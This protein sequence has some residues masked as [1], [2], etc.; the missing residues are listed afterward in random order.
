MPATT[1]YSVLVNAV[2]VTVTKVAISG[3]KVQLTL[4]AAIK[5]GD[6]VKVTYTKPATNPVQ[7]AAAGIATSISSLTATNNLAAPTKDATPVTLTMTVSPTHVHRTINLLLNYASAL[8]AQITGLTPEVVK[9]T[10]T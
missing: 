10:D 8:P 5:Y 9:I 1:S 4:S 7:T 2:A 3:S 6:I